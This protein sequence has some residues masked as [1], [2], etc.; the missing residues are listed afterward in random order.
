MGTLRKIYSHF[1]LN[2]LPE[3]EALHQRY[4][5]ENYQYKYGRFH[6]KPEDYGITD[7]NIKETMKEYLKFLENPDIF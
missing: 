6:Y 5:E 3:T 7:E 1:N 2:L 4:L